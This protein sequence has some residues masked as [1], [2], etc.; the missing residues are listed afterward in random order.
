MDSDSYA[1]VLLTGGGENILV[2][3]LGTGQRNMYCHSRT[4][5]W[6]KLPR[7]RLSSYII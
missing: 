4:K 1:Y 7:C 5:L 2:C 3:Y 6:M